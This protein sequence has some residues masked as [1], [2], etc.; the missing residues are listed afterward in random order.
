MRSGLVAGS[1][2]LPGRVR[3]SA[4]A[5][6]CI[7]DAVPMNEHAPHEGHAL[8]FAQRSL[9]SSISPR[10]NC[11]EYMPNCSSVSKFG[12]ALIVPPVTMTEG[13]FTRAIPIKFPG[14]PL[15][16]LAMNTPASNGVAFA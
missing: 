7:V 6:I 11:A 4:S 15:S 3:P 12:P 1:N 16:Q 14:I 10:S 13:M 9:A 8:C 2:A 5:I